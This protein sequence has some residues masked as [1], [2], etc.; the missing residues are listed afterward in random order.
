M[1]AARL[2]VRRWPKR[3]QWLRA[4]A[5]YAVLVHLRLKR[6]KANA[7]AKKKRRRLKRILRDARF[8]P[9]RLPC[10][11]HRDQILHHD[12]RAYSLPRGASQQL[13]AQVPP[14]AYG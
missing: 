6:P 5:N 9:R 11:F 14:N 13:A 3:G 10:P 12:S 7:R 4:F 2:Y 1:H 8:T